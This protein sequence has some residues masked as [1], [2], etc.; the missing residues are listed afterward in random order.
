MS[1]AGGVIDDLE[2]STGVF[3]AE[4][5]KFL[6]AYQVRLAAGRT[7]QDEDL[8]FLALFMQYWIVK[9]NTAA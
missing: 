1:G 8:R 7:K 5:M 9:G 6:A 2:A 4:A 3:G